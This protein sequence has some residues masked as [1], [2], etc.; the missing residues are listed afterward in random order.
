MKL[1]GKLFIANRLTEMK[2]VV[3]AGGSGPFS[4][5]LE[6]ALVLLCREMDIPAPM[7]MKKNTKE[8]AAFHQTIFFR[9]QYTEKVRFDRFQIRM[10]E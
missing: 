2:E 4:M 6:E 9:E 8:F 5:Q 1:E 10:L 3:T 7:W